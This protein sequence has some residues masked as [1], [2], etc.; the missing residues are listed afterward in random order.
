MQSLD[1]ISVNLWQILISL[2]NLLILFLLIKKF[3]YAPVQKMLDKRQEE[4]NNKYDEAQEAKN[5]A[6][7]DEKYWHEKMES[8]NSEADAILKKASENANRR[9][10]KI[11]DT[12]K[13][14]AEDIIRQAQTDAELERKRATEDIK[15]EIVDISAA[16]AEKMLSREIDIEDHRSMINDVIDE[17]G[18]DNDTNE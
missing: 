16:L 5:K 13:G 8:A 2:A 9:S 18:E 3:L 12:A 11:I 14:E 6:E 15:R 1:V 10:N 17:I 4:L 7:Q